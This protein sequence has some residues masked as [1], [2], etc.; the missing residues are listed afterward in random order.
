MLLE[1]GFIDYNIIYKAI[2]P[3]CFIVHQAP[4]C[5]PDQ[6]IINPTKKSVL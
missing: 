6:N 4:L 5:A 3:K 1:Q 2:Q